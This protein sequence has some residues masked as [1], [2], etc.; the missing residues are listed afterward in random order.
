MPLTKYAGVLILLSAAAVHAQIGRGNK[1]SGTIYDGTNRF[2]G[3]PV[4]IGAVTNTT[5]TNGF[6]AFTNLSALSYTVTPSK[7]PFIFIPVARNISLLRGDVDDV[8]FVRGSLLSGFVYDST[9]GR[10]P[11]V[12]ITISGHTNGTVVTDANGRYEITVPTGFTYT[13]TPSK[14]DYIFLPPSETIDLLGGGFGSSFIG[15]N[16][17]QLSGSVTFNSNAA[18]GVTLRAQK[19]AQTRETTTDAQ[20]H[21]GFTGL[22]VGTWTITPLWDGYFFAPAQQMIIGGPNVSNVNFQVQTFAVSGRVTAGTDGLPAIPMVAGTNTTMTGPDGRFVFTNIA[23]VYALYPSQGTFNPALRTFSAQSGL[24]NLDFNQGTSTFAAVVMTADELSLRAAARGGLVQFDATGRIPITSAIVVSNDMLM[25]PTHGTVTLDGGNAVRL[26]TVNSNVSLTLS[27]LVLQRGRSTNGGAIYSDGGKLTLLDS[28]LS[29]NAV[30]G[31]NGL[32]RTNTGDGLP[33]DPAAAGAIYNRGGVICATNVVFQFNSARSGN[34]AVG[35]LTSFG[36]NDE[37]GAGGLARGGAILNE[38]TACFSVCTFFSNSI[39]GGAGGQGAPGLTGTYPGFGSRGGRG[40]A[41]YGGAVFNSGTLT[42]DRSTFNRNTALSG[43]GGNGGAGGS[44]TNSAQGGSG[45]SGADAG[46]A[47]GA[48][49]YHAEGDLIISLATF[50]LNFTRGGAGGMGGPW[51]LGGGGAGPGGNG[52]NGGSSLG[53]AVYLQAG[54]AL[55][56][57]ATLATNFCLFGVA[58]QGFGAAAPDG[59]A[60]AALGGNLYNETATAILRN[61]IVAYSGTNGTCAGVITDA[62]HNISSDGS[63]AFGLNSLNSVNPRLVPIADNGGPTLTVALSPDSPAIDAADGE[64]CGGVDQR[65]RFRPS[66]LRCDIGAYEFFKPALI[67]GFDPSAG[68]ENEQ[69]TLLGESLAGAFAVLFNGM[70]AEIV[71][72]TPA[73]ITAIVPAGAT[74]GP[75]TI[76][77]PNGDFTTTNVFLI[78]GLPPVVAFTRP[79][80]GSFV[81]DLTCAGTASDTPSGVQHVGLYIYRESDRT[82]WTGSRWGAPTEL[83]ATYTAGSWLPSSALP[84]GA[85]LVDGSYTLY[86]MARDFARNSTTVAVTVTVDKD[87]SEAAI[88]RLENG[89]MRVRFAGAPG[90]T[91]QIEASTNF[92]NWVTIGIVTAPLNGIVEFID[93]DTTTYRQRFYRTV[94]P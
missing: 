5:D 58:G 87:G 69:M 27:N 19:G 41:G 12:T 7:P 15:T 23:G 9:N 60:G 10:I 93:Q 66:G 25:Q 6:Y 11:G 68:A 86:A 67:I 26:F 24:T 40:G 50:S 18:V 76:R 46:Q 62:G 47:A 52:G 84:S 2:S 31:A 13:L 88:E 61:S 36:G 37:G 8:D 45:G 57:H 65:G 72:S 85:Q 70:E 33:G 43:G 73:S 81:T 20:G 34:G 29:S 64:S 75:V 17:F 54:T 14:P 39:T 51:G 74:T 48:A 3:V 94:K 78:D 53:G 4:S 79:H 1:I 16:I 55:V 49:I 71:G 56:T 59:F 92:A 28:I 83:N 90:R 35:N 89:L 82:F 63:A 30:M 80:D 22:A 77:T 44:I 32:L 42:I 38:G 91:Y 21:Y